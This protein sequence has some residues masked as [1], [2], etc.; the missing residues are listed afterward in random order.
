MN[1]NAYLQGYNFQKQAISLSE[2]AAHPAAQYGLLGGAIGA[3]LG[4]AYKYMTDPE[5]G[6]WDILGYGG[7][8]AL[9]GGAL[10]A[11]YGAYSDVASQLAKSQEEVSAARS[12]VENL[13]RTGQVSE[14]RADELQTQLANKQNQIAKQ[15]SAISQLRKTITEN[16]E[17]REISGSG[18]PTGK[19]SQIEDIKKFIGSKP[20]IE[21]TPTS[22]Y[23]PELERILRS[24]GIKQLPRKGKTVYRGP[25]PG[26]SEPTTQRPYFES[27]PKTRRRTPGRRYYGRR[28]EW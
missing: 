25:M 13:K 24:S 6:V 11:G 5:A 1:I 3:P 10:G 21:Y 27:R 4:A 8:G 12:Q 7:L 28:T 15:Q 17:S 20:G 26:S 9:G 18:D 23:T 22:R 2:I 14:Q 19:F 16:L